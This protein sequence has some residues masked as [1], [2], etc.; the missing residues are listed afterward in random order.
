MRTR[1]TKMECFCNRKPARMRTLSGWFSLTASWTWHPPCRDAQ[2]TKG[3]TCST[4]A[5]SNSK[6]DQRRWVKYNTTK[7]LFKFNMVSLISYHQPAAEARKGKMFKDFHS[8]FW[9]LFII[10]VRRRISLPLIQLFWFLDRFMVAVSKDLFWE[11][12]FHKK[13]SFEHPDI[14]ETYVG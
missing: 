5:T 6:K 7:Y 14:G 8:G 10:K 11:A 9:C 12:M 2:T 13:S 1:M 3:G 4:K